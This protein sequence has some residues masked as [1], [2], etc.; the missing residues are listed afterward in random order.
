[1][2]NEQSRRFVHRLRCHLDGILVG[3]E[4][5][6]KDDPRLTARIRGR[7]PCRQPVRVV[8]DSALR[9]DPASILVRTAREVPLWIGCAEA[10]P[11]DKAV[12]LEGAGVE[13]L[14]LPVKE[15]GMD[16]H[17]LLRELGRRQVTSLLVEGGART[18][19]RFLDEGL[20]DAFYF[21]YAP[22]VLGDAEGIPM[23]AG[24]AR[25]SMSEATP[26]FD[27]RWRRFGSDWMV[28]GRFHE[29]IY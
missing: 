16:L 21:F 27:V 2:S 23:S 28:F 18:I 19:G 1:V 12:I 25:S 3:V 17:V 20:A 26:V 14:R 5:A 24:R 22:K 9:I 4:T 29:A 10:V 13:L 8:L 6:L 15:G 11:T 7:Q